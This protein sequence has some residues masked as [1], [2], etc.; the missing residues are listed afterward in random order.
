MIASDVVVV[1][2]GPI[3]LAAAI[4]LRQRGFKVLVA[5]RRYPPINKPC[6]E[7]VLPGGVLALAQLGVVCDRA[8]PLSGIRFTEANYSAEGLFGEN[9]GLGVRRT[10]LHQSLVARAIETGVSLRWGTSVRL[11]DRFGIE[12]GGEEISC[13]WIVGADGRES[14]VRRWAGFCPPMKRRARVG[15]RQHFRIE[16]WT[17]VVEV[18]LHDR[19]QAVV[20]PVAPDEICVSLLANDAESR[21][22]DLL[23]VYPEL[24]RRLA[25]ARPAA[26]RGAICSA[27]RM[28][29]VVHDRIALIGDAAGAMDAITGEGLSLGFKQA[30]ALADALAADD[31]P[32]YEEAHRRLRRIPDLMSRFMLAIAG[33][34]ALRRRVLRALNATP[35]LMSFGVA[36]HTGVLPIGALPLTSIAGFFGRL[37]IGSSF[38][39]LSSRR[40]AYG[41]PL[42]GPAQTPVQPISGIIST[43]TREKGG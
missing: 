19:G 31:L 37:L 13:R 23:S 3:G 4:A 17:D 26:S 24:T 16:P 39:R 15:L 11:L 38:E 35:S 8:V 1:G 30:V 2:G 9:R 22:A 36:V 42:I 12:L 40:E 5:D 43:G 32:A 14:R 10:V 21:A 18:H 28:D 7:G 34:S 25:Q 27:T 33:R 20:T 29:S 41:C 6:G